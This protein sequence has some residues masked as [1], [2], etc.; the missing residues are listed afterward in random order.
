MKKKCNLH[1]KFFFFFQTSMLF[2]FTPLA[3]SVF[4]CFTVICS[5]NLNSDVM[6]YDCLIFSD[7][8]ST[9]VTGGSSTQ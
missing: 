9:F 6:T 7:T 3:A 5:S 8:H 4:N 1:F 2:F